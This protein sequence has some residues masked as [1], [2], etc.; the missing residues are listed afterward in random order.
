MKLP[1]WCLALALFSFSF[2]AHADEPPANLPG[3]SCVLRTQNGQA[4]FQQ[5]ETIRLIAAFSSD[6]P[7][8]KIARYVSD[9]RGMSPLGVIQV[10]P[11]EG[12]TDPIGQLPPPNAF[13]YEG[14]PPPTPVV[15]GEKPVEF[16]FTLN[17]WVRFDAPGIYQIT[18]VTPRVFPSDGS[19]KEPSSFLFF[20]ANSALTTS[21]PLQIEIVPTDENWARAQIESY[22][23]YWRKKAGLPEYSEVKLPP[24]DIRYLGTRAAM[25]A[26]LEHLG[27]NTKPRSSGDDSYFYRP[28][29]LGFAEQNWLIAKMKRF[30]ARPDYSVTQGFLNILAELEALEN[31]PRPA[32]A[33]ASRPKTVRDE[34]G[35]WVSQPTPAQKL[36]TA[37]ETQL[38]R[39]RNVAALENWQ[40]TARIVATKTPAERAMTL[41]SLLELAWMT[42]V[43]KNSRVAARVPELSAQLAPVFDQLPPLPRVYLLTD[44]WKNIANPQFAP[45]LRRLWNAPAP[46]TNDWD[47]DDADDL[48]LR[49]LYQ[50]NPRQNRAL[51]L[52]QIAR[53]HPRAGFDAL[54]VLPDATLP[55]LDQTLAKNYANSKTDDDH[56]LFAR[57]I[58]RYATV[59]IAPQLKAELNTPGAMDTRILTALLAYFL[60]VEPAFGQSKLEAALTAYRPRDYSSLLGDVASLQWN[61]ALER[62]AISHLTNA[63]EGVAIDAAQTLRLYGS[64]AAQS[65]LIA[66]LKNTGDAKYPKIRARIEGAL[67][68]ALADA[69][70]WL[71][72]PSQLQQIR[73]LCRTDAGRGNADEYLRSRTGAKV[74]VDITPDG[75]WNVDHYTGRGT[76]TLRAKLAQFPRG[77]QFS[78]QT[79][80]F[81]RQEKHVFDALQQAVAA[82]GSTLQRWNYSAMANLTGF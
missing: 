81:D 63:G 79:L 49:R 30:L 15:L 56:V 65:A 12:A 31:T 20:P 32:G 47:A 64:P 26:I 16:P 7:G 59:N 51:I 60:R 82:R 24:N 45:A 44:G 57:L 33:D 8:Y 75:Y 1:L 76:Q 74:H 78:W 11:D 40:Q 39:A 43:G 23:Q 62:V 37:Y 70:N 80:S 18:L 19:V 68:S 55:T 4:R 58:A 10:T 72:P 5:G 73:A 41:H 6:R 36:Q 21:T 34:K 61:S 46:K 38:A 14:P 50:L 52:E 29:L 27:D 77:T 67:V 13:F 3:V 17:D 2:A 28:A 22:Q 42:Q 66:R 48:V 25:T 54:E 69:Q 9:R 35:Q 53:P 71:C